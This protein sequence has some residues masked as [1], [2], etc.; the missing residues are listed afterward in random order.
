MKRISLLFS[1]FKNAT[2]G[3]RLI[4]ATE[5]SFQI[6]LVTGGV[7]LGLGFVFHVRPLEF[8]ALVLM[9]GAV[10]VLE[11]LNSVLE[12]VI[13]TIKPRMHPA[14]R[15]I[16]DVM[17]GSVLVAAGISVL[18]GVLIFWPYVLALF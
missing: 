12:R 2:K 5:Q 7:V 11:M 6:Q 15:D 13:D 18:V 4:F 17:A 16:K 9:I 1:S 10:L 14:V 3:V 8:I